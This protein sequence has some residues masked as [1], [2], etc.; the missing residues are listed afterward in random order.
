MDERPFDSIN[1]IP[2]VDVILVLLAIVL[3]TSSFIAS[4]RIPVHLPKE[5]QTAHEVQESR[6][7]EIGV[8]GAIYFGGKT[9]TVAALEAELA[10]IPRDTPFLIRADKELT[11]QRFV[12]VVDVL[13]RL[14]FARVAIQTETQ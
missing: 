2:F 7:I 1:V 14:N 13:K 10:R 11:L 6:V 12:D 5:P 9:E 8:D 3:T 4:G